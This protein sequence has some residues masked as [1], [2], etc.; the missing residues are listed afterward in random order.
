MRTL[1][2]FLLFCLLAACRSVREPAPAAPYRARI[3][4]PANYRSI[5]SACR[6]LRSGDVALRAG[7]DVTSI[8]LRGMNQRDDRYSHCGIVVVE[9]GYPFVY[10][11]IGGEDNPDARLRR[12]SARVFFSPA[13]SE[14]LGVARMGLDTAQ[15]SKLNAIARRYFKAGIPFD[16]DFDLVS[17]DRFYCA[18][19]VC[20]AIQEAVGNP[21]YFAHSKTLKLEYVGVD[22]ITDPGHARIICDVRYKL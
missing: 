16:M 6:L 22:N 2:V 14:R 17:D 20:K 21:V 11:S 4:N 9:N 15:V 10:H 1:G 19:F 5:D 13:A 18:E 12:D 3:D 7:F 8:M